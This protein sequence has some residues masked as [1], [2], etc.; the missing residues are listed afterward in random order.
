MDYSDIEWFS[1]ETNRDLFVI[2]EIVPA[3]HILDS[4]VDYESHSIFTKEFL[5]TVV[6]VM[7]I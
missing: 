6:A 1:L 4:L 3:Y 5:P 7:V 2:F